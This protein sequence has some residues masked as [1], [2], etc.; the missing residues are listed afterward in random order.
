MDPRIQR[1]RDAVLPAALAVLAAGG[2]ANFTMEG[3]AEAAG[4]A[5]ST[6]Y[7][8]WPTKLALLRDA[9]EGLNRQPDAELEM[10]SAR[11]R[12]ERLLEHLAGVLS[13]SL[14]SACIPGLIEAAERH[15][16]V[17]GF[18]HQYSDCRRAALTD[19]IRKGIQAGELPAHLDPELAALALSGPIFYRRLMTANPLPAADIP[20][21]MRQVLGP[22]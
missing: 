5:K 2:F 8:Y 1:T 21:L 6:V 17:A 3:V 13:D 12:I 10:G 7:R 14:L 18:L 22:V 19:V 16:E 9:L 15:P 4:V 20:H 11:A